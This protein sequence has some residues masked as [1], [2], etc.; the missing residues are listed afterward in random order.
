MRGNQSS[1]I[2]LSG[3]I[4]KDLAMFTH[5]LFKIE[6]A[7]DEMVEQVKSLTESTDDDRIDLADFRQQ[8]KDE[9]G[10]ECPLSDDEIIFMMAG[11]N[12]DLDMKDWV[13]VVQ[14]RE[15]NETEE[16]KE[17]RVK[18]EQEKIVLDRNTANAL[19]KAAKTFAKKY[20][21]DDTMKQWLDVQVAD[22]TSKRGIAILLYP[23]LYGPQKWD[24]DTWAS[25]P[26]PRLTDM[27]KIKAMQGRSNVPL[28]RWSYQEGS[29]NRVGDWFETAIRTT[30]E[31]ARLAKL[32]DDIKAAGT[33]VT[34]TADQQQYVP[35]TQKQRDREIAQHEGRIDSMVRRWKRMVALKL[36]LDEIKQHP[37]NKNNAVKADLLHEYDKDGNP[38]SLV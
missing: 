7:T 4:K 35:L 21:N 36:T 27:K 17:D 2:R 31:G 29:R 37:A 26:D 20:L 33:D 38:I 15:G 14:S 6:N 13:E 12:D 5:K 23:K 10:E 18:R 24:G 30:P 19:E 3:L 1:I 28:P 9:A 8:Y 32:I 34:K 22:E 25:I 16:E 11:V